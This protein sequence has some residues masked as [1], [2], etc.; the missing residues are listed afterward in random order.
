[1]VAA[2]GLAAVVAAVV[3]VGGAVAIGRLASGSPER[4]ESPPAAASTL[5]AYFLGNSPTGT[6]LYAEPHPGAGNDSARVLAALRLL[7][8][9]PADPD[10]RTAWPR[11]SFRAATVEGDRVVV[12]LA[13][14]AT[15]RPAGVSPAEAVLGL[16]QAVHTADAAIGRALPLEI[17]A[18]GHRTP[19]ALG[20][21]ERRV[22]RDSSSTLTAPVDLGDLAEGTTASGHLTAGGAAGPD[23]TAVHWRLRAAGG[24][25]ATVRSGTA[26]PTAPTSTGPLATSRWRTGPIDLGGLAAGDYVLIATARATGQTSAAPGNFSDSRDVTIR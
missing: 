21:A 22:V 5:T 26:S 6:R 2:A 23:V 16:Q 3:V 12:R 4:A 13:R 9:G 17:A 10:Y 18:S 15:R 8:A 24:H 7:A 14:A 11:G 20:I 1:V 19:R 25:G